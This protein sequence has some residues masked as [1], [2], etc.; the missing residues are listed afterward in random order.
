MALRRPQNPVSSILHQFGNPRLHN[1]FPMRSDQTSGQDL[2][3][4]NQRQSSP[5]ID[6]STSCDKLGPVSRVTD[7][8]VRGGLKGR[9]DQ[10]C[11]VGK[12]VNSNLFPQIVRLIVA[13]EL[14]IW[15]RTEVAAAV[16]RRLGC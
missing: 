2:R 13:T 5:N 6:Y 1:T 7:L 10:H 16:S 14:V 15:H 12:K 4:V 11:T 3:W 9:Y 8:E